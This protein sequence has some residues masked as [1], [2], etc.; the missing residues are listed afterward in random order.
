MGL[1][2]QILVTI[3]F[4]FLFW[5]N[6][7]ISLIWK[8]ISTMAIFGAHFIIPFGI[9]SFLIFIVIYIVLKLYKIKLL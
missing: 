5:K 8:I 4:F 2:I 6:N 9:G 1:I 7:E 3:F